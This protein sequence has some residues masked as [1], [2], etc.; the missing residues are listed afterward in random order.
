[1]SRRRIRG[2][3]A[4]MPTFAPIKRPESRVVGLGTG[5]DVPVVVGL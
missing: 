4:P 2:T 5:T 1:M 3:P